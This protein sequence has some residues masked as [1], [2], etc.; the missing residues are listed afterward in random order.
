MARQ[1]GLL[2]LLDIALAIGATVRLT[3]LVV[4]DEIGEWWFRKPLENAADRWAVRELA[5]AQAAGEEPRT[6]RWWKYQ[7]LWH[8]P[9]C[10]S[11]WAAVGVLLSG[12]VLRRLGP[13][14]VG[15]WRF[16]TGALAIS[17]IAGHLSAHLD[18]EGIEAV[19]DDPDQG[20]LVEP[21]GS[22]SDVG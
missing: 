10:T 19:E 14:G 4:V 3:R 16:G 15:L 13:V 21:G 22:L 6:P 5:R 8:C 20:P 1:P 9:H 18:G 11:F 7:S 12:L 2:D 17:S